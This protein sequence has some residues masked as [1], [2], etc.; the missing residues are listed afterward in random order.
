MKYK[1]LFGPVVSRRLGISLGVDVVPYKYCSLNCV[2]CEV[3]RTTHLTLKRKAFYNVKQITRELDNFLATHPALDYITFSGAG[4]PTLY[5]RLGQIITY[6]KARHPQYKLALITNSTLF[7]K[8]EVRQEVLACDLLL[9]S[10][11][12]AS[13]ECFELINRPTDKLCIA[14][15]IAGLISL[16]QEYSGLIWLEIFIVPGIND[17]LEEIELL[18]DAVEK[19][20]PDKVQLN[21]LDRPGA[22]EWVEPA[23]YL[24]LE[25]IRAILQEDSDIPVEI[26]ARTHQESDITVSE[27]SVLSELEALLKVDE[28]SKAELAR[29]LK[30]HVNEVSKLLQHLVM[31]DKITVRHRQKGIY[32]SWKK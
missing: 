26:I 32:Y 5:S 12:A 21:S 8:P 30:I 31:Q 23:V 14:E 18:K 9:P 7:S 4:E 10:L 2:Y 3:S 24:A 13:D 16:R 15:V 19:I 29:E 1:H 28:Y 17:H 6:I 11:D 25:E 22:E 27:A 20:Q